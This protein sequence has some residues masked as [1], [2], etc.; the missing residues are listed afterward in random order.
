MGVKR[1]VA[2]QAEVQKDEEKVRH[3]FAPDAGAKTGAEWR[4]TSM[5][6][7][8]AWNKGMG[9]ERFAQA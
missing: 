6:K 9:K 8:L 3:G 2:D 7:A 4:K 5:P 1:H